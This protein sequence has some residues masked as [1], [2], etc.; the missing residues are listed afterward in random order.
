MLT[1]LPSA[2][3]ERLSFELPG[4]SAAGKQPPSGATRDPARPGAAH[5]AKAKC[6]HEH[7]HQDSKG[8]SRFQPQCYASILPPHA[9]SA[10]GSFRAVTP[11]P[12]QAPSEESR[13][14]APRY[15][16]A[17]IKPGRYSSRPPPG[18]AP[19]EVF[20]APRMRPSRPLAQ[21]VSGQARHTLRRSDLP[22]PSAANDVL[23]SGVALSRPGSGR[24]GRLPPLDASLLRSAVGP[25]S[26]PP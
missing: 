1:W 22:R 3:C 20:R 4:E 17:V 6:R 9:A 13:P 18:R 10:A 2:S 8:I 23:L 11:L 5:L 19:P 7:R 16:F 21:R 24:G 12:P 14:S 25:H 15:G 26:V